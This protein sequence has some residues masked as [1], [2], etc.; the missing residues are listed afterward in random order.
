MCICTFFDLKILH[1]AQISF[2]RDRF[3]PRRERVRP[4]NSSWAYSTVYSVR[5]FMLISRKGSVIRARNFFALQ[6][7]NRKEYP[8]VFR[9]FLT[10]QDGKRTAPTALPL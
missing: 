2:Q 5:V 10:Q 6:G 3:L 9:A 7:K 1:P 8:M 4:K